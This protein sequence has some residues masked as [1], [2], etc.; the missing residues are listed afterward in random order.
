MFIAREVA[1]QIIRLLADVIDAVAKHDGSLADQLRRAGTSLVLNL[2]EGNRRIGRDK[3][4]FFRIAAGSAAEADAALDVAVGFRY[5]DEL[6]VAEAR[7]L[8]DRELGLLWGLTRRR[9]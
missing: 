4:H 5:V 2:A 7:A 3:L 9:K 8:I 1:S 6:E